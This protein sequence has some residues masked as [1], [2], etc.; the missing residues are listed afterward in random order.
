[1]TIKK[2][3]MDPTAVKMLKE[4]GISWSLS[5]EPYNCPLEA[6]KLPLGTSASHDDEEIRATK[7]PNRD[8]PQY[9]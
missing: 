7:A 2:P 4:L 3:Q 1:M 5:S 9:V 6:R 8:G